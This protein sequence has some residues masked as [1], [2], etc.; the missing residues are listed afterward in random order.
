MSVGYLGFDRHV[1]FLFLLD[2]AESSVRSTG[3]EYHPPNV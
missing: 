1:V 2:D 3:L